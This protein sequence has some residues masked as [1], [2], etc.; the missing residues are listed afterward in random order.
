MAEGHTVFFDRS[1]LPPGEA[2]NASIRREISAAD[3]FVFLLSPSSVRPGCYAL[4]ELKFANAKWPSP[5]GHVL[6]VLVAPTPSPAVP[7]YLL[8]VT[9]LEPAGN[10]AAEAA[11]A[12]ANLLKPSPV[13]GAHAPRVLTHLAVFDGLPARPA[14]FINVTNLSATEPCEV[15]HVWLETEPKVHVLRQERKLPTRLLPW[16]SWETWLFFDEVPAQ[17]PADLLTSARVRLSTGQVLT[18]QWNESVPDQGFVP[19]ATRR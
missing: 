9:I 13:T 16:E 17:P 3:V 2:Y 1:G 14:L 12:I 15:T 8:A 6:P 11:A 4:S 10:V 7:P 18:S 5:A 19:G